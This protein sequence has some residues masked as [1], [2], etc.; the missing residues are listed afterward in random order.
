MTA[1]ARVMAL[2]ARVARLPD[3]RV[4][5]DARL[6]ELGIGSSIA[7]GILSARLSE[8]FGAAPTLSWKTPVRDILAHAENADTRE[9]AP[10][11]SSVR[12][13]IRVSAPGAQPRGSAVVGVGL[14]VEQVSA[15]PAAGD[16]F[17]AAHF[18][19]AELSRALETADAQEHLAGV[20]AAKEAARKAVP[21]LMAASFL[22]IQ[23]RHDGAGR[24]SIVI[25]GVEMPGGAALQVSISHAAGLATAIVIATA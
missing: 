14:D 24:P 4:T 15:L 10:P 9:P 16:P 13:A 23:V 17:Y 25:T 19:A 20:W 2:I 1:S 21:A 6:G 18:T 8:E 11:A 3:N 22:A 5:A 7:L 12:A